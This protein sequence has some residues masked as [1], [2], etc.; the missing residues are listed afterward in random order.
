MTVLFELRLG[1]AEVLEVS[2]LVG[3][4][5]SIYQ[6]ILK[7]L[8][9]NFIFMT[10]FSLLEGIDLSGC[11]VLDHPRVLFRS[12]VRTIKDTPYRIRCHLLH[13][14]EPRLRLS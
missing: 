10:L 6:L 13:H 3:H 8:L 2:I 7:V 12:Q 4:E 1:H 9:L 5:L 14:T 11:R